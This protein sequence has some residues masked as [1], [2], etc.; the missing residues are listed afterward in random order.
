LWRRPNRSGRPRPILEYFV[1]D[2][3]AAYQR[4]V[5]AGARPMMPVGE[6]FYGDRC[7]WVPDPFGHIWSLT[8]VKEELTPEE[9]HQRMLAH[10]AE[11]REGS[12]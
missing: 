4:A 9:V 7:G 6:A 12:S 5:D 10:A 2:V 8:T 3:D 11:R 1:D